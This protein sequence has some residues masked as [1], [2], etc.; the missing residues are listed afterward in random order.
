MSVAKKK[1]ESKSKSLT[2]RASAGKKKNKSAKAFAAKKPVKAFAAK[3]PAKRPNDFIKL[4]D[5]VW[6]LERNVLFRPERFKYV[7]KILEPS[8]C[9]FCLAAESEKTL[10][11]LCV[12][13]T[14]FS[15]VVL[16]KYPYNSGHLLVLPLKHQGD[17]SDLNDK[18]YLDLML[19]LRRATK[20]VTEIYLPAGFNLGMNHGKVSGA[21]IPDHLHFHIVPRWA[22]DLNFFPLIAE[23]KVVIENLEQSFEKYLNYFS[24]LAE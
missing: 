24:K 16:N 2:P 3:K 20:A 1:A 18:A 17:L 9:V 4:N 6:P 13:K 5:Q 21:G 8:A 22:G 7:R 14:E 19:T 23:T 12:Y 15:M 10:K 11:T